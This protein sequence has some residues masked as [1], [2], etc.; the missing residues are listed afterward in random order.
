[1]VYGYWYYVTY[2]TSILS[3]VLQVFYVDFGNTEWLPE[4]EL[5]D[6]KPEYLHLPFQAIECFVNIECNHGDQ[7]SKE[8]K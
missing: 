1:M 3:Y 8:S 6:I 4:D 7:W 2:F 5:A